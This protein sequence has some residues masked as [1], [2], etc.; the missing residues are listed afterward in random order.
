MSRPP[1]PEPP[2]GRL[3][4]RHNPLRCVV[5]RSQDDSGSDY[6]GPGRWSITIGNIAS[7]EEAHELAALLRQD[8][9]VGWWAK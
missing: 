8:D 5:L 9:S 6:E 4:L 1:L 2:D 7:E 3:P